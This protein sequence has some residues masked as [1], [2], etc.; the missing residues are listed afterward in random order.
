VESIFT[1]FGQEYSE[2]IS[3]ISI[4]FNRLGFFS[5]DYSIVFVTCLPRTAMFILQNK[6]AE[7]GGISLL[8]IK[9]SEFAFL[10]NQMIHTKI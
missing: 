1:L 5:V 9:T 3:W 2:L 10:T 8:Y 4:Y 7:T 6:K